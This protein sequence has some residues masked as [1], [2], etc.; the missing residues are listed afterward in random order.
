MQGV[1]VSIAGD[2]PV[3]AREALI[4]HI[5]TRNLAEPM[6]IYRSC[7]RILEENPLSAR[8]VPPDSGDGRRPPERRD[9]G[10]PSLREK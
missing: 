1:S 6:T 9:T 8:P 5:T 4:S 7:A 2:N 3:L 10:V